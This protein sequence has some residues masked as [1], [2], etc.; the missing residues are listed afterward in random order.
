VLEQVENSNFRPVDFL[1]PCALPRSLGRYGKSTTGFLQRS[2]N[3]CT[4]RC[5]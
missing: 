1:R 2:R 4:R 3:M 5:R